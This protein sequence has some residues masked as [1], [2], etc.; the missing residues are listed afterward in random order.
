MKYIVVDG[1]G[2]YYCT[3]ES[4]EEACALCNSS[5]ASHWKGTSPL[6]IDCTASKRP[7]EQGE[8]GR[9]EP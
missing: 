9:S 1:R 3:C 4:Y 2:V 8:V 5:R 7:P 6:F